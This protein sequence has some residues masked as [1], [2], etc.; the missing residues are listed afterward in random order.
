[1]NWYEKALQA[2]DRID[3]GHTS[4][5]KLASTYALLSIAQSLASQPG[6]PASAAAEQSGSELLTVNEVAEMTRLTPATLRWWRSVGH[7]GPKSIKLGRRVLYRRTD[8]EKW[9]QDASE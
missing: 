6:T 8:V 5:W 9:M 4:P 1:M 7:G 3:S 2:A